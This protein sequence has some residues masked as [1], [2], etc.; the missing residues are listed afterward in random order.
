MGRGDAIF[1]GGGGCV[2]LNRGAAACAPTLL[3]MSVSQTHQMLVKPPALACLGAAKEALKGVITELP[4]GHG[5]TGWL[6]PVLV[7]KLAELLAGQITMMYLLLDARILAFS[8]LEGR[9]LEAAVAGVEPWVSMCQGCAL[10]FAVA[11]EFQ[12]WVGLELELMTESLAKVPGLLLGHTVAK[13]QL[14]E[15]WLVEMIWRGFRALKGCGVSATSEEVE[16]LRT[17]QEKALGLLRLRR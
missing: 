1:E 14:I 7:G 17:F 6:S 16:A 12:P 11:E 13:E 10:A 4:A 8:E 2:K 3:R 5:L 15:Q 9:R